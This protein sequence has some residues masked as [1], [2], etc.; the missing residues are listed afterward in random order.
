M[1]M[2][3]AK[4]EIEEKLFGGTPLS[5]EAMICALAAIN[6]YVDN[7]GSDSFVELNIDVGEE[8]KPAATEKLRRELDRGFESAE[9][10]GWIDAEDIRN[11]LFD[12]GE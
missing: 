11:I 1:K 10:C 8:V 12:V 3:D 7:H 9:Q 2:T 4:R 5:M 6:E